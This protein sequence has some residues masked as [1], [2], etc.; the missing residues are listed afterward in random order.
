M[1][2]AIETFSN[3]TGG[4][5]LF[6]ALGHPLAR[7]PLEELARRLARSGPVA[8]YDPQGF[9]KSFAALY[10]LSKLEL[11]G[12][13]VQSVEQLGQSV[14]G[15]QV[16]PV[17]DL[18]GAKAASV[19]IAAFDAERALAQIRHLVP[20]GARVESFDAGRLP[21]P[22][23]GNRRHYLDPLNFATNLAFFRDG[24]G[25]RTRLVTANYWS[26]YGARGARLWLMLLDDAGKPLA[27]WTETLADAPQ[28][29]VI[30]SKSVRERFGLAPFTGQ[31]FMHVIGAA[32][33]DVV[34]YALDTLGED[35]ALLSCTHD[36]NAWPADFYAG[37]P[38]PAAGERVWLWLQNAHPCPIP[39]GAI[40]LNQM[41]RDEGRSIDTA[42]PGFGTLAVDVADIL[43]GL[44]WPQQIEI[45]AGRHIVRPRY[46][47][48][49]KSGRRRIAH[50]NVER[51]DLKPDPRLPELANLFGKGFILPAPILP[52]GRW[53]TL[54][55]PT[56]MAT[57]QLELPIQL[58]VIDADGRELARKGLGR[59]KRDAGLAVD[60]DELLAGTR[61]GTPWGHV[62][63]IYDFSAGGEAD[64]WLHGLFRYQDRRNGHAADTSFGS[65]MFNTVLTYK[66]EPQSYA[67]RPPG[68]STRLFLRLG[69]APLD[70]ICHLI[71]PASTPWHAESAT[72]LVLTSAKGETIASRHIAIP[73]G[74]SRHWS[75][76]ETFGGSE[77]DRAGPDAYVVV[78]DQT[79]RLFG[80]HG[81][82]G[83]EAFSLDHMFG[84]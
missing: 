12:A 24:D 68:L 19:L 78:R 37:L 56:P 48:E 18:S 49:G 51:V 50:A 61:L 65:H 40:G 63:L 7:A 35:P 9:A 5:S 70:T 38:A 3:Q 82:V 43:P 32:G 81:L 6:K 80:Y 47:V 76:R 14:L 83:A 31:L 8:V 28:S 16:Q 75:Y 20:S 25:H 17:T 53:R 15:H 46:E 34:K 44:A 4:S 64:G 57:T 33:H 54:V 23:L 26:G 69:P 79:C 45:R 73:C 58:L 42:V 74:G 77:R 27:E 52:P 22:L 67:G 10:D 11:A 2:L 66:G 72:E 55:Q 1:A 59:V 30:D 13:Y 62:E 84:F 36:A 39:A 29:I 41:G 71:Y 60:V 21:D